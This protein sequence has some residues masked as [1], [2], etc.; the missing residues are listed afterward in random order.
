MSVVVTDKMGI[1]HVFDSVDGRVACR[2]QF[3][4]APVAGNRRAGFLAYVYFGLYYGLWIPLEPYGNRLP[5]ED[6]P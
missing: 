6:H 3:V 4:A 1:D 5:P 2:R